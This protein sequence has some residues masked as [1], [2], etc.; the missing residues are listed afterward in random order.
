MFSWFLFNLGLVKNSTPSLSWNRWKGKFKT[1]LSSDSKGS[2]WK[3]RRGDLS[4]F[5]LRSRS[6]LSLAHPQGLNFTNIFTLSFYARRSRK[7][8]KTDCLAVF[9]V[10]LGFARA[11]AARRVLVKSAP[12][13]I[14]DNC[15]HAVPIFIILIFT[16]WSIHLS[17]FC[18]SESKYNKLDLENNIFLIGAS[19]KA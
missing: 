3:R 16:H 7:R 11:K 10:L 4:P 8:K 6:L 13:Q 1:W 15:W 19:W 14:L 9:F 17:K 5:C 18:G 12:R 2:N